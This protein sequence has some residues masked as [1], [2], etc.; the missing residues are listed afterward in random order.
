MKKFPLHIVSQEKELLSVEVESVS[1][2]TVEGEI[3]VLNKHVPL[4][5][6]LKTGEL[7]YRIEGQEH[8]VVV[9]EGFVNVSP[10]GEVT[11]MVDS[12]ILARDIS[13][14]KAEQAVKDA[15]ETMEKTQDQRELIMAEAS[16][17]QAMMEIKVAQ[18]SK[19][20]KN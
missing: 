8:I 14:S 20:A 19:K 15:H 7:V 9:S 3:T 4:F 16:L 10:K 18:K 12:G 2:P 1:L 5:S 6:P 13:V 11:V 17:R